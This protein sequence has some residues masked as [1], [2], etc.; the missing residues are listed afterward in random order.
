M[1]DVHGLNVSVNDVAHAGSTDR[2]IIRDMVVYAGGTVEQAMEKMDKVIAV[3]DKA[4]PR[5]VA[6]A[7]GLQSLVLPGVKTALEE[8]QRAGATLALTTGNLESCAWTKL[9]AAGLDHYFV[10][11]GYGSDCVHRSDILKT[12]IERV[13]SLDTAP[14]LE[15]NANGTYA[16]VF[17]IGDAVADMA[18]ARDAG[19]KGIGVLTGAF[20]RKHLEDEEPLI[21]LEDLSD[22]AQFLEL[23]GVKQA[24]QFSNIQ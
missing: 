21:V 3:A 19:A 14:H 6:E 1:Q 22:T 18:A 24:T 11:G 17:H 20:N 16:N 9:K 23:L 5:L 13:L 4:I 7:G 12:A 15:R 2:A 8:L 10:A